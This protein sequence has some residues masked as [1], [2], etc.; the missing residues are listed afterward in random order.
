MT[1]INRNGF[2]GYIDPKAAALVAQA[3]SG[4]NANPVVLAIWAQLLRVPEWDK[5]RLALL[6][7]L[8]KRARAGENVLL[9]YPKFRLL[10]IDE[11]PY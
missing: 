2:K 3:L 7:D 6:L 4:D 8:E 9:E 10:P 5:A 1:I 11:K